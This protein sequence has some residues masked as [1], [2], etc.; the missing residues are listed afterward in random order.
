MGT[1][2]FNNLAFSAVHLFPIQCR[3]E[4][5]R[6]LKMA[7]E[8]LWF[9]CRRVFVLTWLLAQTSPCCACTGDRYRYSRIWS[10]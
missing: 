10:I 7:L 4:R 2:I 6:A 3:L 1:K 5:S 8:L 9:V